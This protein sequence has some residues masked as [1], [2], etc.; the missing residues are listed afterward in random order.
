MYGHCSNLYRRL[1]SAISRLRLGEAR[2]IRS[3]YSKKLP[4]GQ[5]PIVGDN[6]EDWDKPF[7]WS[8]SYYSFTKFLLS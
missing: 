7:A 3:I 1:I 6:S 8:H 4:N 5:P 2:P